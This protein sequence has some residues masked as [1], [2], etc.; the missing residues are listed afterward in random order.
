[1][2]QPTAAEAAFARSVGLDAKEVAR[3]RDVLNAIHAMPWPKPIQL[4]LLVGL[5]QSADA[6][7]GTV[8][9]GLA[10]DAA[11]LDSF[12][13]LL[14]IIGLADKRVAGLARG[15]S[16]VTPDSFAGAS[17]ETPVLQQQLRELLSENLALRAELDRVKASSADG[18]KTSQQVMP[19]ADAAASIGDQLARVD[20]VL[21]DR[22]LGLRMAASQIQLRAGAT[23]AGDDVAFD[24]KAA[25]TSQVGFQFVNAEAPP[26]AR[27]GAVLVPDVI[28]YTPGLARRRLAA[29]G[30][31]AIIA[32]GVGSRGQVAEQ[33]PAGGDS[34]L[35]GSTVRLVVQ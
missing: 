29:V 26:D 10:L 35:A 2:S 13:Q 14:P 31:S 17:G 25:A 33:L 28:G 9:G 22:K 12:E 15:L 1:M 30:L 34:A 11:P 6:D 18:G 19:L 32:K 21:R 3:A 8:L 27:Q 23:K 5:A 4:A 20:G 24:F 16:A 7:V